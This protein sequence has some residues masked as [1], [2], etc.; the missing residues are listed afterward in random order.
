MANRLLKR[1]SVSLVIREMQIK[2]QWA[3]T[4]HLSEWLSSIHLA[5]SAGQD[6]GKREPSCTVGGGLQICE[7]IWKTVWRVLKK[8]KMET[9]LWSSN[10]TSECISEEIQTLIRK[11]IWTLMFTAALFTIAKLWKQPKG[12]SKDELETSDGI[13]LG[14]KKE[15]CFTICYSIGLEGALQSE[16]NQTE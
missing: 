10:F 7:Q 1:C 2:P 12:S 13:L 3:T 5:T 4:S 14:H 11:N 9:A 15:W 6:M 16:I 8:L